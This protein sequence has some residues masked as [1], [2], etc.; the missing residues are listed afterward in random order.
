MRAVRFLLAVSWATRIWAL[1]SSEVGVVDWHKPFIGTPLLDAHSVAPKFHRIGDAGEPTHSVVLT[2]TASNVLAALD[3]VD[4]HIVWR[5]MFEGDE[6]VIGY[7]QHGNVVAAVSG[8]GGATLRLL[9]ASAGHLLFE[10]RLHSP[11]SGRLFDPEMLGT[12]IAFGSEG[13]DSDIFVLSNAH[14][15]RRIDGKTGDV[16]WGWTAPDEAC[17]ESSLVAYSKIISTSSTVYVIGLAKSFAAYTVHVSALSATTG[18]L[19]SSINVPSSIRDGLADFLTLRNVRDYNIAPHVVWLESESVRSFALS[20]ELA[21]KPMMIKGA[22]Y[23]RILDVGLEDFGQIVALKKDSTAHVFALGKEGLKGIWEFAESVSSNR[24]TESI[25]SSAVDKDGRPYVAR[26]FWSHVFKKASAH[27][28]AAHLSDGKGLASGF[29]FPFETSVH[30][31]IS[32]VAVDAANPGDL[33]I[34]ARLALTTSTG[35]VQ[36]WHQD[37]LQWTREEGLSDIRAVELVDLSERKVATARIDDESF[38]D[39][40]KRQIAEA[41]DFPQYATS[42]VK[43]FVT[44]S[45]ASV[46]S[47]VAPDVNASEP[48][49]RDA[50]GFRK[51]IV[52]A[53]S[54]GKLYGI[55]SANGE[56]LWSR[57]FGLGW[58]ANVGGQ[59]LPVKIFVT[60]TVSDG[61]S[62][63]VVLVTQRKATNSLVDT[64]VFHVDA[65]TGDDA[66]GKSPS[67]DIL[68]G[69]DVISGPLVEAFMLRTDAGRVVVLLDEFAQIYLYPNTPESQDAFRRLAPS[70]HIPLRTGR[71]GHRTITGHRI[72]PEPEFTGR[73]LSLPTWTLALPPSE[74]I[75]AIVP[76][77]QQPV[78]SLGKVLGNRTTLYKY[79]NPH[80][81]AVVTSSTS[82][83]SIY[84]VDGSK[85]TIVYHAVL[86]SADSK[87]DVNV[88]LAENWLVYHYFDSEATG[89]NEAKG[90]RIVSVELYEGGGVDDKTRRLD[91]LRIVFL[92]QQ[93]NF[94]YSLRASARERVTV[95]RSADAEAFHTVANENYQIQSFPRRFLD[96]RRPKRKPTSEEM[97]EWLTQ[98]DALLPD[99]PKRVLSHDYQVVGTKHILTSPALLESTSLVF[100]YGQDLFFTRITPS[101]TFDLLSENF[102][103]AQLVL[104]IA[105]LALAIVIAKPMPRAAVAL[106]LAVSSS[107]FHLSPRTRC[108]A[109][110]PLVQEA[111]NGYIDDDIEV[112]KAIALSLQESQPKPS[113]PRQIDYITISDDEDEQDD[114]EKQ[115][116]ADLQR[117]IQASKQEEGTSLSPARPAERQASAPT[118]ATPFLSERAQLEKERLA[119]QKRLRPDVDHDAQAGSEE[120]S[121]VRDAKRQRLSS[122]S[123]ARSYRANPGSSSSAKSGPIASGS[124]SWARTQAISSQSGAASSSKEQLFWEGELR[125]TGNAH[126]DPRKD[127]LPTFRLTDILAPRDDIAFAIVSAYVYNYSW[128]YSLFSPN[129]PVIA[130]AQDPEGQETIKTILPNWIK[131]TPFLRNGMGCMHMKFML[132]F[133]KS[134]RLRIMIS[135]ANMIEYDWR[136]IENTAWVQDVPLRSAPISHDPKAEDFAAAMVRVLRAISVAPAL[137]SHLRNDHPDL[138]LQRLEEFR[139]KW[140]FSKVKVSLVPSI[141]GKHEGW[142]KVILAGHTALMKALRN[143]NAAA[144]KDKE[145]ILECQGSSIGNYSTQWM[146]EFHCSAR[147]ESAQSWLDVSKARRAKLS[148]PP[149]KILFPTSQYV[150]DSALGEAGGGT[151]FCRRNQWEGAKFPRE[152]F[153]Q[154]RSKRGKVLMHSKM[155]LGMF[156]SRPSVFSGSSN[157]SDSE[158]EDEDDPESDQEKLIGWLYVGSHNFTPSA[159]GTLSGSAFNPTLNITNY[160]LGIVLPLRSEEEANRM[161]CWE[162]PPKKY[163]HGKDEPWI[164][165]ESPAFAQ[166]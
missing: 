92:L 117:A 153:H 162:R 86:P 10:R 31:V 38:G 137:V 37:Q 70:L 144:D 17:K 45:Y 80:L 63:Q 15:V 110:D 149:V 143:L 42:F 140:D 67:K 60:R 157:R 163:A 104:T 44:G 166:G 102:N 120:D 21:A 127:T 158:T 124:H 89:V 133:Y 40:I 98:Y 8:P 78:A 139:M 20:P 52:A 112:A 108:S 164:Q 135:T 83:C 30:G 121:D 159:W 107:Y 56:V 118:A 24:Y 66:T 123:S 1:H 59:V 116:Q 64:V 11:E 91:K 43:R 41:Q 106:S 62:P 79:L 13:Q 125:Q 100:A 6:H 103:K 97:E 71:P 35:A 88:V 28:F 165:S 138:P 76:R 73:H 115:F 99:D 51:V 49:A 126:V 142:P 72:S 9:D 119:R 48:L 69:V 111:M 12:S 7:K 87:C 154:S 58:A 4:G 65:L 85:G 122:S 47:S 68:Q 61:D 39:R 77:T 152:L 81:M 113:Y 19:I 27:I 2:A 156:R 29:T 14:I 33:Q 114:D 16:E 50:F 131:T 147:G 155:I 146:N 151:M 129:T 134:G 148:F 95:R 54:Q 128:L 18:E 160:E 5:Y 96:P 94:P 90:H 26:V 74:D 25:Y 136:D 46:S 93:N 82:R 75:L 23:K 150:R 36:L 132:L 53:T 32:H 22:D 105:G 3:P 57:V 84:L 109:T 101:N 130:V 145:V 161:V 141:A 55:D 34:I